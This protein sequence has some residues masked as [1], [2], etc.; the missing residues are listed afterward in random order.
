M[1]KRTNVFQEVV[2]IL[3]QHLAGNAT[4]EESGYLV[5]R[6]TG[7]NREVDV[8]IRSQVAGYEVIVC[9]EAT[10]AG[11]KADVTWVEAMIQKHRKLPTSKFILVA[12]A[13]FHD[14]ARKQAEAE[15][16][17][18][19]APE[20][21]NVEDPA[22]VVVNA[23]PSLWP[24]ALSLTPE[25]ATLGR[26]SRARPRL[27]ARECRAAPTAPRLRGPR[28]A[29]RIRPRGP[30]CRRAG[31]RPHRSDHRPRPRLVRPRPR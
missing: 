15:N 22:F 6:D 25:T 1:P 12:Q 11:R 8:V 27:V 24:K 28:P 29:L 9:V 2:A 17:V 10:A 13:G 4:V 3:Q 14:A 30:P 18:P 19:L 16:A 7:K 21:L 31:Y 26:A 23:L 20:D 5:H